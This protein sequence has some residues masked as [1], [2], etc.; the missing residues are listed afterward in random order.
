[1]AAAQWQAGSK[2]D[3]RPLGQLAAPVR[4]FPGDTVRLEDEPWDQEM[5]VFGGKQRRG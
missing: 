4:A 5:E 3:A 2:R 1:M